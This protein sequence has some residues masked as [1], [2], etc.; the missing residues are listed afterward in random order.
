[1]NKMRKRIVFML[2]L[3]VFARCSAAPGPQT[4]QYQ[5]RGQVLALVPDRHELSIKHDDIPGFMPAM[6]MAY[7]VKDAKL[8][9]GLSRGDLIR[10]T[11]NVRE[12]EAWLSAIQRT[13]HAEVADTARVPRVMD[14]LEPGEP[15]PETVLR[16][17]NGQAR[18]LTDWRGRPIAV[19]FVYTR[20]PMPDFCPLM[21]RHFAEAQQRIE[22][23]PALSGA[24]H[25][26]A[27]SF[28]PDHDTPDMLKA[29][30]RAQGANPRVWTYL[31]GTPAS[32][33]DIASR[34][35]VSI[36]REQEDA[37]ALTHNLRTAVIDPR[38]RL[39]KV[40]SGSDWTPA[41]LVEDLREARGRR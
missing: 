36:M 1:M 18:R 21:E 41:M 5:L 38:G 16:D 32:I 31:T 22:S 10:A 8:L 24:V 39:V 14:V 28:D 17:E 19:T 12:A 23:D 34:F 15:V 35:G 3:A 4:R 20:C 37:A 26:V 33:E 30:G 6:T 25:L 9:E 29:H 27:I 11:L 40:Y 7:R 2:A 13:G